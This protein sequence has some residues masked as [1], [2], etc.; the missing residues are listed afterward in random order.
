MISYLLSDLDDDNVDFF[1][2]LKRIHTSRALSAAGARGGV[3]IGLA[4]ILRALDWILSFP[5][6]KCDPMVL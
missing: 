4:S 5:H 1:Y 3:S 6:A 2:D